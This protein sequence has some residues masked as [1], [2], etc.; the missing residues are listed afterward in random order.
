MRWLRQSVHDRQETLPELIQLAL[1]RL[2]GFDSDQGV[3]PSLRLRCDGKLADSSGEP[4]PPGCLFDRSEPA[5]KESRC[6]LYDGIG[7]HRS[8]VKVFHDDVLFL[9]IFVVFHPQVRNLFLTHQI[10]ERVLELRM[11]NEEVVLGIEPRCHL[12][13]LHSA[14]EAQ[15]HAPLSD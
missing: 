10:T 5:R 13:T 1:A 8:S 14:Y 11:L 2:V 9:P 3:M 4:A 6:A 7:R 12:G 15:E